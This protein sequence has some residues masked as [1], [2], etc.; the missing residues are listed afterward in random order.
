MAFAP[1]FGRPFPATF[2]RR[3]AAAW[4]RAGGAPTP[5]AVYQPK[6]SASLAASYVNLANPGAYDAAPGVA[7]TFA[8]GTGWAFNG[9][10]QY[11]ITGVVPAG[12]WSMLV[13]F[14]NAVVFGARVLVGCRAAAASRFAVGPSVS[15]VGVYYA[16]DNFKEI[17]PVL[18]AGVLGIAA[19]KGYRNGVLDEINIGTWSGSAVALTIGA[20]N[21]NG[22]IDSY[23]SGYIQAV[24]IY[25]T[26]L[27]APQVLAVSTAMAAL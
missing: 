12:G 9:S 15:G 8:A 13:L 19:E 4:W 27:T 17:P 20:R 11:L 26:T 25:N 14:S 7:P 6:G 18:I 23:Y 1:V 2:D 24:A 16:Y 3:A 5:V 10:S 21:W 22:T